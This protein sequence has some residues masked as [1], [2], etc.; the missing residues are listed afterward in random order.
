MV[1][2]ERHSK[3]LLNQT[4]FRIFK[5][6]QHFESMCDRHW[7]LWHFIFKEEDWLAIL[8]MYLGEKKSQTANQG[9][10]SPAGPVITYPS[11]QDLI[12]A[13]LLF[14]SLFISIHI[15]AVCV[16]RVFEQVMC[17]RGQMRTI[18]QGRTSSSVGYD[19]LVVFAQLGRVNVKLTSLET[20]SIKI[21]PA[22]NGCDVSLLLDSYHSSLLC[23]MHISRSSM[24]HKWDPSKHLLKGSWCRE[25]SNVLH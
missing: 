23:F 25:P 2:C 10:W 1:I 13:L 3:L 7:L 14:F 4:W 22:G 16:N 24:L 11:Q 5:V 12:S 9:K 21:A 8:R 18:G 20:A 19:S 17:S 15:T 6:I